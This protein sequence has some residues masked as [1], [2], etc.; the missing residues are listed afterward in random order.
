MSKRLPSLS[1]ERS[2]CGFGIEP[3]LK[4]LA[5][6]S[7]SRFAANSGGANKRGSNWTANNPYAESIRTL[8][9]SPAPTEA[10]P[11]AQEKYFGP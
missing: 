3:R 2:A 9:K 8:G 11:C 4:G 5:G 6:G 7:Y 10:W 1:C